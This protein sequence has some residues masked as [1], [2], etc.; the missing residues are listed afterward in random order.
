MSIIGT[1]STANYRSAVAALHRLAPLDP[2][3]RARRSMSR[4]LARDLLPANLEPLTYAFEELL[5]ESAASARRLIHDWFFYRHLESDSWTR[6][7]TSASRRAARCRAH[8]RLSRCVSARR[9]RCDYSPRRLSRRPAPAAPR[10]VGYAQTHARGATQ[11]M[12]RGRSARVRANRID[13]RAVDGLAYRRAVPPRRPCARCD[14]ATSWWC[15]TTCRRSSAALSRSTSSAGA[16]RSYEVPPKSR[17]SVVPTCCRCSRT[18]MRM[19][20]Q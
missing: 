14:A 10:V 19:A 4:V 3:L 15:C 9:G 5:G 20:L 8:W 1:R 16:R 6:R 13:G 11:S 2:T 12:E 18:T 17:C 7:A